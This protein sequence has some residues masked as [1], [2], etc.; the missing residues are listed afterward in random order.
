MKFWFPQERRFYFFS[1]YI[2]L[3]LLWIIEEVLTFAFDINWIERS[4]AYF[5]TIEAAFGLLSIIGIYFLFQEIRNTKTDIESAKIMI[6]GLKNKNQFLVQTNQSFWESLQ[7]QLEEWDLSEK[8]IALLLL[9]GMSNHQIAAI[10]GKS[11]KTIE[12]QTFSIYQKSGTT[13]KLEFIAYFISPL[14]PEED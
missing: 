11:L 1:M 14:L 6:E 9:R 13:G 4:Q 7:R 12:N 2:F 10:R 8:E 3:I 5:T